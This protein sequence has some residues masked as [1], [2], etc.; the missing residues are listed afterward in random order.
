MVFICFYRLN[1]FV[2]ND[3]GD[4]ADVDNRPQTQ[5]VQDN[6]GGV[7]CLAPLDA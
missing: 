1:N 7:D 2:L 3:A 5:T 4:D 6:R